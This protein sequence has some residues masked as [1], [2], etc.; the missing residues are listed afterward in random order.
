MWT[1]G[2]EKPMTQQGLRL[3]KDFIT[4]KYDIDHLTTDNNNELT[5]ELINSVCNNHEIEKFGCL[6]DYL[7]ANSVFEE[8]TSAWSDVW[9]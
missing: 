5:L 4:V 9:Y 8:M 6:D 2:N 3:L 1:P 7:I